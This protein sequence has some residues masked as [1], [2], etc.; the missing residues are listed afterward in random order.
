MA[1]AVTRR[2]RSG[3]DIGAAERV[4]PLEAL[5]IY[6]ANGARAVFDEEVKGSIEAGKLADLV[7]LADNPL[8]G[9]PWAIKDIAVERTIIGGEIAYDRERDG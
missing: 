4:T 8:N 3:V 9:D 7:V 5:R 6:T 1:C 2:T